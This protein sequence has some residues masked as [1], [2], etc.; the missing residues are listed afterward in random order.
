MSQHFATAT[1][2]APYAGAVEIRLMSLRTTRR[3]QRVTMY[4][5]ENERGDHPHYAAPF[6]TVAGAVGAASRHAL[7]SAIET[8]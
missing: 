3:G 5:W 2:E 8:V 4:R 1:Y 6:A 7:I